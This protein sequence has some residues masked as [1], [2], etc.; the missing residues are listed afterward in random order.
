MRGLSNGLGETPMKRLALVVVTAATAPNLIETVRH[1]LI[2][3]AVRIQHRH[4]DQ[5]IGIPALNVS[6]RCQ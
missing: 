5:D 3:V 4:F 2:T 1:S 6:A